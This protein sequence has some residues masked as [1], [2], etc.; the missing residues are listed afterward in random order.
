MC[1]CVCVYLISLLLIVDFVCKTL[2]KIA[3]GTTCNPHRQFASEKKLNRLRRHTFAN[4]ANAT[5]SVLNLY[6]PLCHLIQFAA[7]Q[8]DLVVFYS[9][10]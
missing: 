8:I 6:H 1:V 2:Q 4:F 7:L 3:K 5:I 9:M 10:L